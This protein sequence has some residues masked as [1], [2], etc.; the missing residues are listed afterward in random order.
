MLCLLDS[1]SFYTWYRVTR[2]FYWIQ[3]HR[4]KLNLMT[5]AMSDTSRKGDAI[6]ARQA[7]HVISFSGE[8]HKSSQYSHNREDRMNPSDQILCIHLMYLHKYFWGFTMFTKGGITILRRPCHSPSTPSITDLTEG[9]RQ[10]P[11][12]LN[13]QVLKKPR[14]IYIDT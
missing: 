11:E 14:N 12:F 8:P 7:S 13:A 2:I 9:S 4:F 1:L 6:H 10:K 5:N 3:L